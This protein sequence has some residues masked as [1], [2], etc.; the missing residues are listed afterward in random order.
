M[1]PA[2]RRTRRPP[3]QDWWDTYEEIHKRVLIPFWDGRSPYGGRR[4]LDRRVTPH[5][6]LW[7]Q[8]YAKMN[9]TRKRAVVVARETNFTVPGLRL[10]QGPQCDRAC[11]AQG[12]RCREDA[13]RW[14]SVNGCRALRGRFGCE[15]CTRAAHQP[16]APGVQ[17]VPAL[18][19]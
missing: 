9:Y 18:P 17:Q 10:L 3:H 12:L 7:L 1:A 13:L 15:A 4:T 2:P 19:S 8:R 5:T 14:S 6:H 16:W 11:E